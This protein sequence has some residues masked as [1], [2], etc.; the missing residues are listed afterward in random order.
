MRDPADFDSFYAATARR[1]VG[2]VS[3]MTG[4]RAEAED[5]VA[6]AYARAWERWGKVSRYG[7]PEGWVRSVAWRISVSSWRKSVSRS[8]AHRRHGP[9]GDAPGLSPDSVAVIAALRR[10]PASQRHAVVLY[11][12]VGLTVEE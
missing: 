9:P 7:D 12:I 6:E 10:I 1:V 4:D 3:A 5:A 8:A 2:H 11:H